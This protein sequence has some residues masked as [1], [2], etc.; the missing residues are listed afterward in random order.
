[1]NPKY[2]RALFDAHLS[3]NLPSTTPRMSTRAVS[4]ARPAVLGR[5]GRIPSLC[6]TTR[7]PQSL[8]KA[9]LRHH[10]HAS[11][12][13]SEDELSHFNA[14][15]SSWWDVNGPQRI[16][17][18]MN[19]LRMDFVRENIRDHLKLNDA[20][21]D[22]EDEVY[23]PPYNV[24]L[25]PESIRENIILDQEL[26][27]D[28]I[29]EDDTM[30]VLDVGCGGGILSESMARL[31]FVDLVKGIDLSTDVLK[32]A[33]IHMLK[34][35]MLKEKLSY[36]LQAIEQ[37]PKREKYDVITLFE[38]LEHVDYPANILQEALSRLNS[39]GWLFLST[40][41]RDFVSW[42][43]TIFMG[44]HLLGIVPVGTHTLEKYINHEEIKQWLL[45][46]SDEFQLMDSRGCVYIPS[47][48]W[49]FTSNENCGNYFMAIRKVK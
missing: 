14:L 48:G 43:T 22:P 49:K 24:N 32:A 16:L 13:S 20:D 25:L 34:D 2:L 26:R 21:T 42:F 11:T 23:I 39:N 31:P 4:G 37:I 40:I 9:S 10:S 5:F 15:A 12:G 41:N 27:R 47:Y 3:E 7:T 44:E 28:E 36:K 6:G 33:E 19:L 38:I 29:L 1:M 35:P 46:H 8:F 18:K 30:K 17:H 45:D